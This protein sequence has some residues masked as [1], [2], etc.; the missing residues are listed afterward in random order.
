MPKYSGS[1]GCYNREMARELGVITAIIYNDIEDK[2]DYYK[3]E[4][5]LQDGYFYLSQTNRADALAIPRKSYGQGLTKLEAAKKIKKKVGYKPGTTIKATWVALIQDD[6]RASFSLG[7]NDQSRLGENDQSI[8]NET[9]YNDTNDRAQAETDK[10]KMLPTTLYVKVKS[11]FR[12]RKDVDKKR[13]LEGIKKLQER[14]DDES[15]L[16]LAEY[17]ASDKFKPV[18][19]EDGSSWKPNFFWFTNPDKTES[20]VNTFKGTPSLYQEKRRLKY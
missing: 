5:E 12:Q 4:G 3:R 20:V 17:C 6:E 2:Y 9:K 15:I 14:L 11:V 1:C 13:C 16:E 19:R 10:E 7:E 18:S 8:Y